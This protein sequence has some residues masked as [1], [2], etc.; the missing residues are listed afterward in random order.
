MLRK[1]CFLHEA[2][3]ILFC[4]DYNG[5]AFIL[6]MI[7]LVVSEGLIDF[8]S[9]SF[10]MADK[11]L[12]LS[13]SLDLSKHPSGIVPTLQVLSTG[14]RASLLYKMHSK[15]ASRINSIER[16]PHKSLLVVESI[17]E[18]TNQIRDFGSDMKKA[19]RALSQR[20]DELFFLHYG[21]ALPSTEEQQIEESC[22]TKSPDLL[23]PMAFEL[24]PI[25]DP[26]LCM[27]SLSSNPSDLDVF[28][29]S[30]IVQP[31]PWTSPST[32]LLVFSIFDLAFLLHRGDISPSA[33]I[34]TPPA[35]VFTVDQFETERNRGFVDLVRILR[36]LESE[37]INKAHA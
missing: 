23:D 15:V 17:E 5:V 1:M 11:V 18:V 30:S 36:H 13:Q 21:I 14:I 8:V 33:S 35:R 24:I 9:V 20:F 22:S 32:P 3:A 7:L 27:V 12:E 2:V 25:N 28:M 29:K 34:A 4:Q 19:F 6:N 26:K 10:S 37:N 31:P 16:E